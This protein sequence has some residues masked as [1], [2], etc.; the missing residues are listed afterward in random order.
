[1]L[2]KKYPIQDPYVAIIEFVYTVDSPT[3][4]GIY[5]WDEF[6]LT[7]SDNLENRQK[8]Q[9]VWLPSFLDSKLVSLRHDSWAIISYECYHKNI[10]NT[11][12][13]CGMSRIKAY[14]G[15]NTDLVKIPL[16]IAYA[17]NLLINVSVLRMMTEL[18]VWWNKSGDGDTS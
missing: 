7:I 11:A 14:A 8:D 15:R 6:K 17:I 12:L 2:P 9:V 10:K 5:I 3:I 4:K 13:T 16:L 1:M 18:W